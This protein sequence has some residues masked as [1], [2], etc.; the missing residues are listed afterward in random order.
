[1]KFTCHNKVCD[2]GIQSIVNT[3]TEFTTI[4]Q[5]TFMVEGTVDQRAREWWGCGGLSG[6]P[7][8][9][10]LSDVREPVIWVTKP[11]KA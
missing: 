8:K 2:L 11:V 6:Q 10:D 9:R 5:V 7:Y 4:E 3:L 1:M